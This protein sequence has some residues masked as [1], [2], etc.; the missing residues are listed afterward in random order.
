MRSCAGLVS[1]A[2]VFV[3]AKPVWTASVTGRKA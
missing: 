2:L 3:G 1:I